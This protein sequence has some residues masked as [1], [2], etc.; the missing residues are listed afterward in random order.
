[1][2]GE[3]AFVQLPSPSEFVNASDDSLL[4]SA[5]TSKALVRD[6]DYLSKWIEIRKHRGMDAA[7]ISGVRY[8][9]MN[10]MDAD[11]KNK[12]GCGR[13]PAAALSRNTGRG[14]SGGP[15]DELIE[16]ICNENNQFRSRLK[17]N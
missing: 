7:A 17:V 4:M 5:G 6:A 16:F 13:R 8:G 1:M 2:P 12:R 11:R 3:A 9:G 10:H 14:N 15:P